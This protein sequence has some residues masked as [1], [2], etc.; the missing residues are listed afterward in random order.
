MEN[1]LL[2]ALLAALALP[3]LLLWVLVIALGLALHRLVVRFSFLPVA[4]S[5][6]FSAPLAP[7]ASR[8]RRRRQDRARLGEPE[9]PA[10][11]R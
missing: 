3:A 4:G 8:T 9:L 7:S 5:D 2:P 1:D 6:P 10:P 11:A